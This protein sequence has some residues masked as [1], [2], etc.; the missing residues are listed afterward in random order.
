MSRSLLSPPASV[1]AVAGGRGPS[2]HHL[3]FRVDPVRSPSVKYNP[4]GYLR[5]GYDTGRVW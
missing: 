5:P 3:S 1:A 2:G 4:N